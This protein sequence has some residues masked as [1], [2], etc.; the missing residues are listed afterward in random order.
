MLTRALTAGLMFFAIVVA[1]NADATIPTKDIPN[2]RD[3]QL[4][5]RYD[6]SFIVSYERLAFT[7]FK[8][9]LSKL[10]RAGDSD[11]DRMNNQVYK[12]KKELEIEGARTRVAYLLPAGRSPL[13]VL[14]NY[15]DVVKAAGGEVLYTCKGDDCGGDPG[16]SSA[17]GGGDMSLLM[18]FVAEAQLKDGDFSNGKCAQA[19]GIDDQRFFAAKIPQPGGEAYV[20][21]QTFLV[22]DDLY[23]K[24]FNERTVAVV[25]IVEPKPR[26]QKMVVVKADDMARTIGSTGRVALY[27]IFFDTDKADLKQESGPTLQE[28]AAL[29]SSDPKLAVLIVGHTDNQ[30]A[31]DYNLDLSRRRA[32]A[33]VKAL[34]TS[35]RADARR[36]RAAGV[37]ML[38]PAASN[39]ADDGRAKNRR[40]EVVK[41]N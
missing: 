3:N 8:V 40:V 12:P 34:T 19:S 13:E 11:R 25:H 27:G 30:G 6:G 21:V 36:L 1:A 17:G 2:A 28:I 7:D 10:E 37:G 32:E 9:P 16:R 38:A 22:K 31:Y 15:Q 23:C 18:Y 20:T 24:A 39:D 33:V 41:L 29:L 35:Y 4:L 5:K 14:R 26:E